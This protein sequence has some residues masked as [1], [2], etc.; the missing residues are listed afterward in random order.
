V[1]GFVGFRRSASCLLGPLNGPSRKGLRLKPAFEIP[2]VIC[3]HSVKHCDG[4]QRKGV[5]LLCGSMTR[6]LKSKAVVV[7]PKTARHRVLKLDLRA[8]E[9]RAAASSSSVNETQLAIR[10]MLR[11]RQESRDQLPAF[12]SSVMKHEL[13]KKPLVAA[14]HQLLMFSFL[15]FHDRCVFRQPIGTAKTFSMAAATLFFMG[16]DV[17]TRG[18]VLSKT[19]DLASKV[20]SMVSN[21]V[22]EPALSKSLHFVFDHLRRSSRPTDPWT[23]TKITVDRPPGIRDP[24][25][26]AAGLDTGVSG[27]RISWLI[28]DDTLDMDNTSTAAARIKAKNDLEGRILSRL[29]VDPPARAV[30]TNTPWDRDDLTY[31]L[32]RDVGWP[33]MQMDIYGNITI[34]NADAAWLHEAN[35]TLIRPSQFKRGCYRLRAHDPD[36]DEHVPLWPEKMSAARIA[37]VRKTTLPHQF[38]RLYMCEPFDVETQRCQRDWVEKGKHAGMGERLVSVYLGNNPTFCGIDLGI[39]TGGKSDLTVFF[40]FE[41]LPDGRRRILN[42]MSG[43]WSGPEIVQRI[44]MVHDN[45][46]CVLAVETNSAQDFIRQFAI[47]GRKDVVIKAHTTGTN[48]HS[49]DFGVESIFAELQNGA[50]IIP[51]DFNG[52]CDVE[53]QRWI[54]DM[55]FYQPSKH[56]GDFLMACWIARERSRRYSHNDPPFVSTDVSDWERQSV[57]SGY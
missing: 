12:Y 54:D 25:L 38:A 31:Y 7:K 42:V 27:A 44:G 30:F 51:C 10:A 48:K 46:H 45:Y 47:A 39:G 34:T 28:A 2:P 4:M 26:V 17:T 32:E 21:Y 8:D 19:Q 11:L 50:W 14:A 16:N 1:E 43:R 6:R 5:E 56:T 40:I 41:L 13:T 37:A 15:A 52:V 55:L 18:L 9:E 57:R 3:R 35:K 24:T 36:P 22:T 23:T 53:V 20:V 33:T 29:D 49:Q